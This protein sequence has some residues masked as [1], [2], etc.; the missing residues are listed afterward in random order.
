M[1]ID[2]VGHALARM[3]GDDHAPVELTV[4]IVDEDEGR[5]L[6]R[7][8]RDKDK[9]TNVLA[10]AAGNEPLSTA[11]EGTQA[12][13][14]G[15]LVICAPVVAREAVE[16]GKSVQSHWCHLLVHGTLHL[17]GYDHDNEEQALEMESLEIR[18]LA[19]RGIDDP[20]S[21]R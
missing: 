16:Q 21:E 2:W 3:R 8:F 7:R 9:A 17:L 19:D 12:L 5:S 10:F 20:Y 14:L 4:R 6:N 11:Q 13:L 15:D 1:I 18:I